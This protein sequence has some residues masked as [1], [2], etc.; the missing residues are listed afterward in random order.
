MLLGK[1]FAFGK[2]YEVIL[3][4]D[5]VVCNMSMM[6]KNLVNQETWYL[7]LVLLLLFFYAL[8]VI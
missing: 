2:F 1:S 7:L 3:L 4:A 8:E 5:F 6:P